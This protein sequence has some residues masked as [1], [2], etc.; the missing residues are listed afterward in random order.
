MQASNSTTDD[1]ASTCGAS[2]GVDN[3]CTRMVPNNIP[4]HNSPGHTSIRAHTL[5]HNKPERR[6]RFQR[7]RQRAP[8]WPC[9]SSIQESQLKAK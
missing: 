3:R 2:T 7:E 1:G 6:C 9:Q 8:N 5:V 4:E